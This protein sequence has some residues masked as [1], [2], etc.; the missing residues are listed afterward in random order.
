MNELDRLTKL[1][2]E[3]MA[4]L[5]VI[6]AIKPDD[7]TDENRTE[8]DALLTEIDSIVKDMDAE[9]RAMDFDAADLPNPDDLDPDMSGI[10]VEDQP[11]YRSRFPL[12]EQCR[13]MIIVA[14]GAYGKVTTD[15]QSRLDQAGKRELE[16]HETRAAGVGMVEAVGEDGG[17]LLQ[18]ESVIDLMTNGWNN[19]A[20]LSRTDSMT[21]GGMFYDQYGIDE[22]SRVIGSRGGGI[23]WYNDKELAEITSSKT[24]LKRT[25]W[26]PKRLTGLYFISNEINSDVPALQSEMNKL[27][28]D[29][30]AFRKQEMVFRG[31]GS[32]E[33]L[34]LLTAPNIVTQA[35]ESGQTAATIV[36]RN[37]TKMMSRIHLMNF[38]GLVWLVN[39][40][41]MDELLNLTIAIGT[42]GAISTAFIPNI[43]GAPGVI[44][45]LHG[46][47][48]IPIE[49]A[50][51][52]GTKGDIVLTDL[53][54]YKTVD[55]GGVETAISGHVKFLNNQT[56]VRFVTHFDGM[57]K[58]KSALTPN[59]GTNTVSSTVVLATRA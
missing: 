8:R 5:K 1:Y 47:P 56:A 15:A 12:G 48:V 45:T 52:L 53:S 40:D 41:T 3:A 18:G 4:K 2:R 43:G 22:D 13:D 37:T 57:P 42:G 50:S 31:T 27:F 16:I 30:L 10:V 7:L 20:V 34:G 38:G 28:G 19:N 6:R 25:R 54:Q 9:K 35:K 17:F 33:A 14:K 58:Q 11:I 55:R 46:Y 29:E 26:E 32:G 23:R 59:K 49:Q 39:Q 36:H 21:I 24:E 44:G 51:T